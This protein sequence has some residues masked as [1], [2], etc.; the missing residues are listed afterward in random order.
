M[1]DTLLTDRD[2]AAAVLN[3]RITECTEDDAC[4]G[5]RS[6]EINFAIPVAMTQDMQRRLLSWI[7]ELVS[8]PFNQ[9]KEGVH[10]SSF[11]GGKL[12]FSD[13]D[14]ALLGKPRCQ[15]PDKPANGEEP[16]SQD[17]VYCVETAAKGFAWKKERE[18]ILQERR[19]PRVRTGAL[20]DAALDVAR[21][22]EVTDTPVL[23]VP[24]FPSDER[25]I[26]REDLIIEEVVNELLRALRERDMIGTA[27]GAI[28]SI[29]VIV[30]MLLELGCPVSEL[31]DEVQR[32]N[33]TKAILQPDGSFKVVRR[34]DGKIL[35]PEGWTP[36][37]IAGILRAHGW[38]G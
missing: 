25:M 3:D 18:R 9:P 22:H 7:D 16:V 10:W 17:D 14:A 21:F 29:Y 32:A 20:R 11:I 4:E 37:D 13:V 31:W 36:P 38:K 34:A 23:R 8:E 28:D 27:D 12:K 1:T 35:K 33:M 6:I 2:P 15:D 5:L 19:M 26:L 24:E 30:G